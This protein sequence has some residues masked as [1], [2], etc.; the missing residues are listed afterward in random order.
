M[1]SHIQPYAGEISHFENGDIVTVNILGIAQLLSATGITNACGDVTEACWLGFSKKE[2]YGIVLTFIIRAGSNDDIWY[3]KGVADFVIKIE[4]VQCIK[5]GYRNWAHI[6]GYSAI[7]VVELKYLPRA[8]YYDGDIT[9][10]VFQILQRFHNGEEE[11]CLDSVL[12]GFDANGKIDYSNQG[13]KPLAANIAYASELEEF[14]SKEE[15][16][17]REIEA[18]REYLNEKL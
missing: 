10:E 12:I 1:L 16:Y 11:G 15:N 6:D 14:M 13:T 4:P 3:P 5:R 2:H 17:G 18:L 9:E 8:E 7:P